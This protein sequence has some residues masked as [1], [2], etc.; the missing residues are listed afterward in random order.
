MKWLK[1][2]RQYLLCKRLES[3]ILSSGFRLME[4]LEFM[5][6]D[7]C[8]NS[9][10]SNNGDMG[11]TQVGSRNPRRNVSYNTSF[12]KQLVYVT[13]RSGL[14]L[15]RNPIASVVQLAVYLF[16]GLSIGIVYFGLDT[17]LES[18]IQNRCVRR[19]GREGRREGEGRK[20]RGGRWRTLLTI[21]FLS[22]QSWPLLL[23][24]HPNRVREHGQLWD[25]HTRAC[26]LHVSSFSLM[27]QSQ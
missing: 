3:Q 5:N 12:A 19:N 24:D 10:N 2:A 13:W 8:S 11:P 17:S 26:R 4:E 9:F 7:S 27:P 21:L 22:A 20:R 25:L 23:P 18:G 16:F 14:S 15:L 6:S 1:I